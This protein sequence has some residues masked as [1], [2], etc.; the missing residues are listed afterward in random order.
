MIMPLHPTW[1][2]TIHHVHW[3]DDPDDMTFAIL[4]ISIKHELRPLDRNSNVKALAQTFM[5]L[6]APFTISFTTS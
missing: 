1:M 3:K 4:P 6:A 5:N 2:W